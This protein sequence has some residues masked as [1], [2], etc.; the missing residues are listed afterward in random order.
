MNKKIAVIGGGRWGRV[1]V[2]VLNSLNQAVLWVTKHGKKQNSQWLKYNHL[3]A[4]ITDIEHN[5]FDSKK[6]KAIIIS[7]SSHTHF[8]LTKKAL[9]NC[10]PVLSEKPYAFTMQQAEELIRLSLKKNT[11]AAVNLEFMYADYLTTFKQKIKTIEKKNISITWH[12]PFKEEHYGE[13]KYGDIYTPLVHDSLPHCWSLFANNL[14]FE[15]LEYQKDSSLLISMINHSSK[16]K[17]SLNRRGNRRIRHININQ[18]EAELDFSLEPGF[19]TIH[20][21]KYKN[22]WGEQHP[23]AAALIHFLSAIS[24]PNIVL[25]NTLENCKNAV[26]LSQIAY[27]EFYIK[28]KEGIMQNK[29]T[30]KQQEYALY[31]Y[32]IPKLMSQG[33]KIYAYSEQEIADF[34]NKA[35]YLNFD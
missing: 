11:L 24:N 14:H 4:E 17:I 13:I 5:A 15:S 19:S 2:N 29:F 22:E 3:N 18:G 16:F 21:K 32:F 23:L 10:I 33:T 35:Q 9:K 27:D 12:D 31:D 8:N 7:T 6:I 25:V 20:G 26:K 1:L 34:L 28:V 30:P